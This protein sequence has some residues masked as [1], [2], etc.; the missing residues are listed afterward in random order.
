MES[1]KKILAEFGEYAATAVKADKHG[2]CFNCGNNNDKCTC[3]CGPGCHGCDKCD[4]CM[5]CDNINYECTCEHCDWCS[6]YEDQHDPGCGTESSG[7]P[8]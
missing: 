8:F 2:W 6:G 4:A 7:L 1:S 3:L 5:R